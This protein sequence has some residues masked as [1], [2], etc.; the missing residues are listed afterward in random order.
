[1]GGM[2][3]SHV[4][5]LGGA[6]K[7]TR[8]KDSSEVIRRWSR[9]FHS[10]RC[11][12]VANIPCITICKLVRR[13]ASSP[14]HETTRTL[15]PHLQMPVMTVRDLW[16]QN[17]SHNDMMIWWFWTR[18]DLRVNLVIMTI[19]EETNL[20]RIINVNLWRISSLT[21]PTG[22]I[23]RVVSSE[24]LDQRQVVAK[25]SMELPGAVQHITK[26]FCRIYE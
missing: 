9:V 10:S 14:V 2:S 15:T 19:E 5:L 25:F 4:S 24:D 8:G 18:T 11:M 22:K 6:A 20:S 23:E 7:T 16:V 21:Q 12:R 3:S 1:M 26:D 13:S 17:L